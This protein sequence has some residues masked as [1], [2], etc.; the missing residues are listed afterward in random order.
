MPAFGTDPLSADA[1]L[2]KGSVPC[3]GRHLGRTPLSRCVA[4][5]RVR[6]L[7]GSSSGTDPFSADAWLLQG[8]VPCFGRHLGRTPLSRCLAFTRIRPL[9]RPTLK[10]LRRSEWQR[11]P[12]LHFREH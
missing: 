11:R 3:F 12:R 1:W 7:L 5:T 2:L 6:P 8:S 10:R 4:F 9:L